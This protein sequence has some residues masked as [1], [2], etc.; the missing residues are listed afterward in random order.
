[1]P[2]TNQSR[3]TKYDQSLRDSTGAFT[4]DDWTSVTDIGETFGGVRLTL[5]A[6]LDIG[7][8]HLH[9]IASFLE[10]SAVTAV[11]ALGVENAKG[12]FPVSEGQTLSP[13]QAIEL[14]RAMLRDE[15]WCRLQDGD[16]FYIHVGWDYYVYVGSDR[17]CERSVKLARQ[18]GLFIDQ[19][20][21]SLT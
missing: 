2:L 10:E 6:Y 4:G 9:V 3:L 21:E 12:Q 13:I 11:T 5:A 16:G 7:A 19:P 8:R 20:F 18:L 17:P 15:V 14:V 1:M